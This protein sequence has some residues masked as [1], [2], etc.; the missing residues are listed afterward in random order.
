MVL[1]VLAYIVRFSTHHSYRRKFFETTVRVVCLR[2][3]SG[4]MSKLPKHLRGVGQSHEIS[5]APALYISGVNR[6]STIILLPPARFIGFRKTAM[7]AFL[8]VIP[9]LC[10]LV[11]QTTTPIR[12]SPISSTTRS[13][14]GNT[15]I[16]EFKEVLV[17]GIC[18]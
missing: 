12:P 16:R 3:L 4:S 15:R 11:V 6:G 13:A 7:L 14:D 8:Y 9:C 2:R 5:R 1:S 17:C 10:A 18:Q